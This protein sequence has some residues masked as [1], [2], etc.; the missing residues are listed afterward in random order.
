[1][2]QDDFI[3]GTIKEIDRFLGGDSKLSSEERINSSE[4]WFASSEVSFHSSEV[5]FHGSVENSRFPVSYLQIPPKRGLW[6]GKGREIGR[7]AGLTHYQGWGHWWHYQGNRTIP[8]WRFW[9]IQRGNE[10]FIGSFI[11]F[12]RSFIS[13]FRS[14]ISFLRGEF[15]FSPWRFSISSVE[16]GIN[17]D[18]RVAIEGLYTAL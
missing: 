4:L 8:R 16:I 1:M 9:I 2:I 6:S 14:F 7:R 10:K 12:F 17:R 13:F 3:Y 18:V 5:L 11:S 15:S